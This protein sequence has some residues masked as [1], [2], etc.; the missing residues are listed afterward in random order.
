MGNDRL[1]KTASILVLL[2]AVTLAPGTAFAG[3]LTHPGKNGIDPS[4]AY[5][6]AMPAAYPFSGVVG[7]PTCPGCS[8]TVPIVSVYQCPA[9]IVDQL[10]SRVVYIRSDPAYGLLGGQP[11]LY[12]H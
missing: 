6:G 3:G 1:A 4:S 7:D 10:G 2:A 5:S 11:Y 8:Y 9:V 12:H